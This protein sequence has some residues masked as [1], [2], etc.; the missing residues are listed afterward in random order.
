MICSLSNVIS[1]E[2]DD[3][4]TGPR[5]TLDLTSHTRLA[6]NL[7]FD[8]DGFC[9]AFFWS[10]PIVLACETWVMDEE[11]GPGAGRA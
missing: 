3:T 11:L 8:G 1:I 2:S 5:P 4:Q 9:F 10:L 7:H 6:S